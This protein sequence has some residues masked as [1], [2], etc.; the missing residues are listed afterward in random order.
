MWGPGHGL[1]PRPCSRV[2]PGSPCT[3]LLLF[4]LVGLLLKVH[5]CRDKLPCWG[6]LWG[7]AHWESIVAMGQDG[8]APRL[9]LPPIP[10]V[11]RP[12]PCPSS[13]T[14]CHVGW[15]Q[16][17]AML[18]PVLPSQPGVATEGWLPPDTGWWVD[19]ILEILLLWGRE[20]LS[21]VP[22]L[23][24]HPRRSW[25]PITYLDTWHVESHW[26]KGALPEAQCPGKLHLPHLA[27]CFGQEDEALMGWGGMSRAWQ[28]RQGGRDRQRGP[29]KSP[30]LPCGVRWR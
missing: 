25:V 11:L 6:L 30:P 7:L 1:H 9:T 19:I 23:L 4:L 10:V 3:H 8:F 16:A 13:P 21:R 26:L 15:A 18:L 17:G 2:V 20:V 24:H 14:W 29:E 28:C 12:S 27:R 22:H 5:R